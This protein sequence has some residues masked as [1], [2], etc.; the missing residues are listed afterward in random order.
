MKY[1]KGSWN[2]LIASG[3]LTLIAILQWNRWGLQILQELDDG[4]F[5]FLGGPSLW[6]PTALFPSLVAIG[7]LIAFLCTLGTVEI[8]SSD[9]SLTIY[10]KKGLITQNVSLPLQS[11]TE[12]SISNTE[13]TWSALGTIPLALSSYYLFMDGISLL[14]YHAVFGYGIDTGVYYVLQASGNIVAILLVFFWAPG[15]MVIRSNQLDRVIVQIPIIWNSK[16]KNRIERNLIDILEIES[17]KHPTNENRIN[18]VLVLYGMTLIALSIISRVFLIYSNDVLRLLFIFNGILYLTY[19]T[20]NFVP[21]TN[22]WLWFSHPNK[23]AFNLKKN[24]WILLSLGGL[25]VVILLTSINNLI[26]S[27]QAYQIF[28]TIFVNCIFFVVSVVPAVWIGVKLIISADK[29]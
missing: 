21:D 12:V 19:G 4:C 8:S 29:K 3:V 11:I 5:F 9:E 15:Q 28:V 13:M 24:T 14:N 7:Y 17:K 22:N 2:L 18:L 23:S 25:I 26:F 16:Q 10:E 6:Y 20:K 1:R 27:F